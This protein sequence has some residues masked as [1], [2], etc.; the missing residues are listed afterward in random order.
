M[1]AQAL[2]ALLER[3]R[4]GQVEFARMIGVSPRSVARWLAVDAEPIPG[5]VE[6]YL[7]LL[8]I[9]PQTLREREIAMSR[10][11]S[12][13]FIDGMYRVTM[14]AA[15]GFGTAVLVFDSGRVTGADEGGV[16][17]D[18]YFEFH[19]TTSTTVAKIRVTVPPGTY[20]ITGV[21]PPKGTAFD[22]TV[23]IPAGAMP[24]AVQVQTPFGPVNA[25]IDFVRGMPRA[26]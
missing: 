1:Q 10:I 2:K 16:L 13:L 20:L 21:T 14:T 18:G 25:K 4:I 9:A 3:Y 17:Y 7:R 11:G 8:E 23:Q 22:I 26:A 24:V 19:P 5:P 15:Q 6:A 12:A